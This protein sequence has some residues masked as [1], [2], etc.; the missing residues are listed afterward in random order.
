MVRN[1]KEI[2][3]FVQ[4]GINDC[5][6]LIVGDVMLDKY[7]FGEVRRISPEAPVPITRVIKEKETL[8]GA[9]NVAHNLALL[10]CRTLLAGVVGQDEHRKALIGLLDE[11]GI[12]YEGLIV[13][14]GPTTTKLRVIG[15]HQQMMRLDFEETRPIEQ[16]IEEKLKEY[17]TTV[18]H[19]VGCVIISD[20]NKGVCTPSLCQFIIEYCTIYQIPV[21]VD[22][23]GSNW[24]KYTGA[25]YITPNLKE[26]NEAVH[27]E[28]ANDDEEVKKAAQSIRR[29]Y[30]IQNV[31]VTRSERGLSLIGGRRC[32]H[33]PTHAQ[34]VFDVSGAGDTV[35][36][37]VGLALAGR[38]D[39]KEA[40]YL[41]NMAA[42]VVV[43]KVGTYAINREELLVT[44][45]NC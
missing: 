25:S 9:G 32:V 7:Y 4:K 43:G 34:E 36:A 15:G 30:H 17:I 35:I 6:V 45:E 22:P 18:V 21:I 3:Q 5:S 20:Y 1:C 31:V 11:K 28:V 33:I 24:Q 29:K 16:E 19:Q 23:K 27:I 40:A 38:L 2:K 41:A 14:S 10:G 44:L 8:G 37:V 12:S 13:K 42:G 39:P 26:L